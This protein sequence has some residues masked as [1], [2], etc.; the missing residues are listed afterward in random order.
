MVL[1]YRSSIFLFV[2]C[3]LDLFWIKIVMTV[4]PVINGFLSIPLSFLMIFVLWKLLLFLVHRVSL[5]LYLLCELWL[6][7][8]QK[9]TQSSTWCEYFI[10]W[11]INCWRI[12]RL[13]TRKRCEAQR[14]CPCRRAS[15]V[16]KGELFLEI[17]SYNGY[18]QIVG[19]WL[20]VIFLY[21]FRKVT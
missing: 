21:H 5:V 4:F 14:A 18:F 11:G 2:F 1:L 10:E 9:K 6:L 8:C 19:H 15:K 13:E 20:K 7:T 17:G 3:P 16:S 12:G